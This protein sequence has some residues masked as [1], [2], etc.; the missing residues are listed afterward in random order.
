MKKTTLCSIMI[1]SM[2]LLAGCRVRWFD[3]TFDMP[4]YVIAVPIVL[5]IIIAHIYIL[6]GTYICPKCSTEI[7]PR[8]Y[9]LFT[10]IH[11]DDERVARC[12]KCNRLGF[13]KRK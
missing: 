6:S 10:Y 4:W 11:Y 1:A 3:Q 12:P 2:L 8:W 5:I 7:K 13:C 9:H